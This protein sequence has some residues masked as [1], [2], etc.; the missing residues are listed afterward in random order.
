MSNDLPIL[1]VNDDRLIKGQFIKCVDGH[2][3]SRDGIALPLGMRLL[4][5][6]TTRAYQRWENKTPTQTMVQRPNTPLPDLDA[7]NA[8]IPKAQWETGLDGQPRPPWSRQHVAY[9]VDV[10][11]ASLFTFANST[12]GAAIAVRDLEDRLAWMRALRGE[13]VLPLVKLDC[14]PLKTKF[15]VKQRPEFTVVEWRRFAKGG[16]AVLQL[17]DQSNLRPVEPLSLAEELRD[18]IPH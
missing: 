11:S 12:I 18:E 3:V 5:L 2:W 4:A 9:F 10:D 14:R 17:A 8:E 13:N 6:A 16:T 15:G 1:S 7:L